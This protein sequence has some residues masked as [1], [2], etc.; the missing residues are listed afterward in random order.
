MSAPD[1]T[2]AQ[3]ARWRGFCESHLL[4]ADDCGRV[5]GCFSLAL[6]ALECAMRE[7]DEWR[8]SREQMRKSRD[9]YLE[10]C[11]EAVSQLGT[12]Q[13]ALADAEAQFEADKER[14]HRFRDKLT[15]RLA[16]AE[17]RGRAMEEAQTMLA[18]KLSEA[19]D[20]HDYIVQ[21][22]EGTDEPDIDMIHDVAA[23]Y[24]DAEGKRIARALAQPGASDAR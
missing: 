4:R 1:I 10:Q 9:Y 20:R 7:R 3:I 6:D 12:A 13:R 14:G 11:A 2:A 16:D 24:R 17:A 22:I 21:L 8:A 18:E 5:A 23:G 19:R 15:A